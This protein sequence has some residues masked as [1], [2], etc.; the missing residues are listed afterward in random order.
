MMHCIYCKYFAVGAIVGCSAIAAREIIG[1][2]LPSDTPVY[3]LLSVSLVYAVGIIAS[4]YGHYRVTF[5]HIRRKR[6]ALESIG[7]FT[8][9]ALLGM[10]ITAL[11]SYQIRYRLGLEPVFG[12][13]L[14]ALALIFILVYTKKVTYTLNTRYTFVEEQPGI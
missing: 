11:L 6:A 14:P 13:A 5:S 10:L 12:K 2:L 3:Y 7:K 1:I 4:F 9:I 8:I